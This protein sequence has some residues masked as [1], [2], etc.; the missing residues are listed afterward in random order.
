MG[1]LYSKNETHENT[2]KLGWKRDRK[3][4][5][6]LYMDFD[7][8]VEP[9]HG[10]MD[11]R[12]NCPGIYTQGELGSCTANAI[13]ACYEYDEI[14][15]KEDEVFTPSRLFIY[16]NERLIEGN[17]HEDAGASIRDGIK[18]INR[19]GVV[20]EEI[21]PYDIEK[22]TLQPTKECYQEAKNHRAIEYHRVR[23]HINVM[24]QC[25]T[26]GLPFTFGF[27]V[28]EGFKDDDVKNTGIMKLPKEDE[29]IL[30]GHAVVAVGYDDSRECFIVRNS[31]GKDWGDNGHFYMP[32]EFITN[33]EW[34]DDFWVVRK[35]RDI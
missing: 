19:I 5:R 9:L 29:E 35:V 15:Q 3:D 17:V 27:I 12:K 1:L 8:S 24:K 32:Y 21:W 22:F 14:S 20:P 34:C 16:Y 4:N 11:L 26:K 28:F 6:D 23:Q 7:E 13:A 33:K 31:W 30:G 18:S 10:A 25:L 2:Y